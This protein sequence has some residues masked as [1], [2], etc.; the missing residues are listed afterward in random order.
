MKIEKSLEA[1]AVCTNCEGNSG[2]FSGEV[3]LSQEE[4]D[5]SDNSILASGP[6]IQT[7]AERHENKRRS[8]YRGRYPDHHQFELRGPEDKGG[9]VLGKFT[10]SSHAREVGLRNPHPELV[11]VLQE[12]FEG[13]VEKK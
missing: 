1:I 8:E 9:K 13:S 10:I 6:L 5:L 11:R 2:E 4:R 12:M 3:I 7:C